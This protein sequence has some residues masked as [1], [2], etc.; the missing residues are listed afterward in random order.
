M[1][2][3]KMMDSIGRNWRLL[4]EEDSIGRNRRWLLARGW[5]EQ[6]RKGDGSQRMYIKGRNRRWLLED[7]MDRIGRNRR[8]LIGEGQEEIGNGCQKKNDIGKN[9]EETRI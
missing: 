4:L 1:V 9:I 6:N 2:T 8:W 5:I 3:S 7:G